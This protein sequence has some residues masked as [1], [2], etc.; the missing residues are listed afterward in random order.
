M[1]RRRD[2]ASGYTGA[3]VEHALRRFMQ[4]GSVEIDDHDTGPGLSRVGRR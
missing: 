2:V 3:T 1:L 4:L